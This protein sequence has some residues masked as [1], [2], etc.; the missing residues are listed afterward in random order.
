MSVAVRQCDAC[1]QE[2]TQDRSEI[3]CTRL[4]EERCH[5]GRHEGPFSRILPAIPPQ[6]KYIPK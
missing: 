6:G 2:F 5:N 1:G 3:P 4:T